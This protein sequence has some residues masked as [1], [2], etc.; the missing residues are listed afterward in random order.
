MEGVG[1]HV[2][3][4]LRNWRWLPTVSGGGCLAYLAFQ[5]H[6]ELRSQQEPD[7]LA[8]RDD[9][10][11]LGYV[12]CIQ[13]PRD[14][15]CHASAKKALFLPS[16]I[17]RKIHLSSWHT[18][19]VVVYVKSSLTPHQCWRHWSLHA[20]L[21]CPLHHMTPASYLVVHGSVCLSRP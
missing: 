9:I 7:T 21:L 17:G 3:L 4:L 2:T 10:L 14:G 18:W 11:F 5:S 16:L 20:L 6:L 8:M 15:S 1:Y 12:T 19:N 13:V